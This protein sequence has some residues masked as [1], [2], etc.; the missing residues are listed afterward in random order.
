MVVQYLFCETYVYERRFGLPWRVNDKFV[1][2]ETNSDV[3]RF[4]SCD[5]EDVRKVVL[6]R[7]VIPENARSMKFLKM[8]FHGEY[9]VGAPVYYDNK[10]N[11]L[12][13]GNR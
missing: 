13:I 8:D 5:K 7:W 4:F 2:Y 6:N 10:G 11:L 9:Y 12:K 3:I 1:G